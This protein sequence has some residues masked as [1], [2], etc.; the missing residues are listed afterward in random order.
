MWKKISAIFRLLRVEHYVK[1]GLCLFAVI[2]QGRLCDWECLFPALL[3][4]GAFCA[5]SSC[6][7]VFNDIMD[8]R[9]DRLHPRKKHRP[10]PSGR[11]SIAT[12]W[13]VLSC[14][15]VAAAALGCWAGCENWRAWG[16]LIVYLLTNLLYSSYL[17]HLAL[18]DVCVLSSGFLLRLFYGAE[19]T[20]IDISPWMFLT[21]LSASLFMGLGKRRNEM[22]Y[23]N[24]GEV[25]RVLR[26]Y[27][28]N[29][30]D[31]NMYLMMALSVVF[32]ALWTIFSPSRGQFQLQMSPL[33]WTV[34]GMIVI[35]MRYSLVLERGEEGDPVRVVFGDRLLLAMAALWGGA[36]V[37]LHSL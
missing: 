16:I 25:R 23:T 15:A 24:S 2:F 33:T 11:I 5:V 31:R 1:N 35:F 32:Y 12:A 6:V 8:I 30:L 19:L 13:I 34:P 27:S 7:Y 26:G 36:V 29:F 22:R 37:L 21:V 9:A 4:T 17:K 18:V 3:G 20:H 28:W 14:C 10:L